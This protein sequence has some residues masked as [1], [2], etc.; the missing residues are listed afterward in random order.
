MYVVHQH[1]H[2]HWTRV[3]SPW[4]GDSLSEM[5][6]KASSYRMSRFQSSLCCKD[7]KISPSTSTK[8]RDHHEYS[9]ERERVSQFKIHLEP[10]RFLHVRLR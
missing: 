5:V 6:V 2:A 1:F 3:E 4:L 8:L 7:G 10:I 9:T